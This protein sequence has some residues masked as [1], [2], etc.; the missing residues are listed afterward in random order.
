VALLLGLGCL[1]VA[2]AAVKGGSK[3]DVSLTLP[4]GPTLTIKPVS[5]TV[6]AQADA[7]ALDPRTYYV[8]SSL[9]F[10]YRKP[11][12][13]AWVSSKASSLAEELRI[14]GVRNLPQINPTTPLDRM[15][16]AASWVRM[17][18]GPTLRVGFTA[19][20]TAQVLGQTVPLADGSPG[21]G[22]TLDFVDAVEV[23]VFDKTLLGAAPVSFPTF[24]SA[25]TSIYP[26]LDKLVADTDKGMILGS[27]SLHT[28]GALVNGRTGDLAVDRAFLFAD[29]AHRFYVV[30]AAY[31][32]QTD[33]S[34]EVWNAIVQALN[35]FRVI[36]TAS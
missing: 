36:A 8:D 13:A 29:S 25:V 12:G 30:E 21:G 2:Y 20:S 16:A 32:P 28:S 7:Q 5:E 23:T 34:L 19:R 9:G 11:S 26:P 10:A 6:V 22:L 33:E 15:L 24:F 14:K 4:H 3:A 17:S 35:S 27:T 18:T 1:F 31:S